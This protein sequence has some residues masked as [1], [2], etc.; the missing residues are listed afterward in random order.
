MRSG[1]G[2]SPHPHLVPTP[3]TCSPFM[4]AMSSALS[5]SRA[6][7]SNQGHMISGVHIAAAG[8][9]PYV[10]MPGHGLK[11]LLQSN[12]EGTRAGKLSDFGGRRE[13][14]DADAFH[15]AARELC[16]ETDSLFGDV[17]GL[18]KRIREGDSPVRILNPT[19]RWRGVESKA[20]THSRAPMALCL[21]CFR[22]LR[23]L[24][25]AAASLDLLAAALFVPAVV[26][27]S[28][29]FPLRECQAHGCTQHAEHSCLLICRYVCFF[30]KVASYL[31][32]G[33]LSKVRAQRTSHSA[34]PHSPLP[35]E[36]LHPRACKG[37][38]ARPH[39][40]TLSRLF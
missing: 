26:D 15:T 22:P 16:E 12:L 4:V 8:V 36:R 28:W 3:S 18:A 35:P 24:P 29:C 37:A 2:H 23:R 33:M 9:V 19:G 38:T 5:L 21:G 14:S 32:A 40:C 27:R 30:L 1:P 39:P 25:T 7:Q 31:P 6:V 11:F 20:S 17:R 13:P 34:P 10:D